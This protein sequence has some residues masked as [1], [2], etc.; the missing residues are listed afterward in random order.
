MTKDYMKRDTMM[1]YTVYDL[2]CHCW[3]PKHE[4]FLRNIAKRKARRN[5]K[6][7]LDKQFKV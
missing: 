6:Q 4:K 5:A 1:V 2:S 7:A 3:T